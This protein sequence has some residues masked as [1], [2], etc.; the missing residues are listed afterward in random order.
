MSEKQDTKL[1]EDGLSKKEKKTDQGRLGH[2]TILLN[3]SNDVD[4]NKTLTKHSLRMY[5]PTQSQQA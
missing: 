4:W 3:Q 1:W 2:N 5:L